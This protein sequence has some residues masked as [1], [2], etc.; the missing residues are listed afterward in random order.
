MGLAHADDELAAIREAVPTCDAKRATCFGIA[1]HMARGPDGNG[2]I[3]PTEYVTGQFATANQH[4]EAVDVGFQLA[5][6]DEISGD[7]THI[8]TK[9][10]RTA[11]AAKGLPGRV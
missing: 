8:A 9:A 1:L 5:S 11:L 3:V 7:A 6:V 10:E 4:F 2:F